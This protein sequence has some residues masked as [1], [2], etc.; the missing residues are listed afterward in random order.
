M[1]PASLA[2]DD[3]REALKA[4]L[5][6]RPKPT[7]APMTREGLDEW[8][9]R[10]Q[11]AGE[12]RAASDFR[13]LDPP[14]DGGC[15]FAEAASRILTGAAE[16]RSANPDRTTW[17]GSGRGVASCAGAPAVRVRPS[18]CAAVVRCLG[19]AIAARPCR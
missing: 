7:G 1:E 15:L 14:A 2:D 3:I 10:H 6:A 17:T 9:A 18:R 11:A 4:Q 8:L 12:R 5:L 13:P 19:E 16:R